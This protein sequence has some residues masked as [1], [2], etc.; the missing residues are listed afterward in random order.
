MTINCRYC[1]EVLKPGAIYC[2]E[3]NHFQNWQRFLSLGSS[4]LA[5]LIALLSVTTVFFASV[6]D[7]FFIKGNV[8]VTGT[9][10]ALK[11][12]NLSEKPIILNDIWS[13]K[14]G[15]DEIKCRFISGNFLLAP[16]SEGQFK[17][18]GKTN[19]PEGGTIT[20]LSLNLLQSGADTKSDCSFIAEYIFEGQADYVSIPCESQSTEYLKE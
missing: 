8:R 2:K 3:C 6:H 5:L 15:T 20:L 1:E 16:M 9:A 10:D 18:S 17:I 11:V 19:C 7:R 4:T 12:Y 14:K 13:I